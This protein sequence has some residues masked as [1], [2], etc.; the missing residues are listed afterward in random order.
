MG[1]AALPSIPSWIHAGWRTES[2]I[3]S[4]KKQK[5]LGAEAQSAHLIRGTRP[6]CETP[7][8]DIL[9]THLKWWRESAT[10][11]VGFLYQVDL[12]EL[13]DDCKVD[14]LLAHS[15]RF[16]I[17]VHLLEDLRGKHISCQCF[18]QS[19]F[20]LATQSNAYYSRR[21]KPGQRSRD[22]PN[23]YIFNYCS[24]NFS[25]VIFSVKN[26]VVL[27]KQE[28]CWDALLVNVMVF[29]SGPNQPW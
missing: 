28:V 20:F 16:L 21:T 25:F 11:L 17:E 6:Q 15:P 19:T 10:D 14:G 12:V 7:N 1:E 9:T 3:A 5:K 13:Q 26:I 29:H 24:N 8:T 22:C 4:K 27:L 23:N 18:S 2:G